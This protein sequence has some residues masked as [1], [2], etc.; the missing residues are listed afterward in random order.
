[1]K[2]THVQTL[3]SAVL[4][5]GPEHDIIF[6]REYLQMK[7]KGIVALDW[8]KIPHNKRKSSR[9]TSSISLQGKTK[10]TNSSSDKKENNLR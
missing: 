4:K 7:D 9:R 10:R 5:S 2:N 8:A 6:E 1:M 3:L